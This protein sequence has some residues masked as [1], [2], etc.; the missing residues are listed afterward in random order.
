MCKKEHRLF[1]IW[2]MQ[3]RKIL[4]IGSERSSIQKT[5]KKSLQIVIQ[6]MVMAQ[7]IS[8]NDFIETTETKENKKM[9]NSLSYKIAFTVFALLVAFIVITPMVSLI[10]AP[11]TITN[12]IVA[13]LVGGLMVYVKAFII[14]MEWN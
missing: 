11:M 6:I 2:Q 12:I 5:N 3:D 14:W 10:A 8:Y 7:I 9:E 4:A 13:A 1:L